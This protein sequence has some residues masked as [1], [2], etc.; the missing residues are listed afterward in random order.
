M[1]TTAQSALNQP[2][3]KLH[4]LADRKHWED[5]PLA[6][7]YQSDRDTADRELDALHALRDGWKKPSTG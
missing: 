1:S 6:Q 5:T 7:A 4:E 2:Q 3:D